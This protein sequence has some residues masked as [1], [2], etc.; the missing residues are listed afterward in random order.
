MREIKLRVYDEGLQEMIYFDLKSANDTVDYTI[1]EDIMLFTGLK[2]KNGK[3]IYEGDIVRT[4]EVKT[5]DPAFVLRL[6]GME[7]VTT[8]EWRD[9]GFRLRDKL[10]N[11]LGEDNWTVLAELAGV[12][13]NKHIEIEVIG[14]LYENPDLLKNKE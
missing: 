9:G 7:I 4:S 14:N 8:V 5:G 1:Y 12:H 10:G 13:K 2:D 3:E 6:S 11:A